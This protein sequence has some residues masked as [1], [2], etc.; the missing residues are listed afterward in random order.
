MLT[1]HDSVKSLQINHYYN[2]FSSIQ[3][4]ELQN[5]T[6]LVTQSVCPYVSQSVPPQCSVDSVSTRCRLGVDQVSTWSQLGVNTKVSTPTE[7]ER[8]VSTRCRLGVDKVSTRCRHWG[9][10]DILTDIHTDGLSDQPT[11]VLEFH[12]LYYGTKNI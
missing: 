5:S 11:R 8:Q 12:M 10:T 9:G 7:R 4:M 6:G 1:K 3:H 2:I